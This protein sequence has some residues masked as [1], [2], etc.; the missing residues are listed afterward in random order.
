M[1]KG[2]VSRLFLKPL[3]GSYLNV[4]NT[5]PKAN[6]DEFQSVA[7]NEGLV[8]V[9]YSAS[10]TTN[11]KFTASMGEHEALHQVVSLRK[12]VIRAWR[13]LVRVTG[14]P[15]FFHLLPPRKQTGKV[16]RQKELS[17]NAP[18]WCV[19]SVGIAQ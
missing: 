3:R 7:T 19:A 1:E 15:P 4:S 9:Q 17:G 10:G 13:F 5:V 14:E 2:S 6:P 11:T 16:Y 8:Y 12:H 18:Q